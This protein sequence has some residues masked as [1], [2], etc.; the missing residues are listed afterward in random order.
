MKNLGSKICRQ[1]SSGIHGGIQAQETKAGVAFA[2]IRHV[3]TLLHCRLS[4]GLQNMV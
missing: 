2:Y 3:Y 1:T 4:V